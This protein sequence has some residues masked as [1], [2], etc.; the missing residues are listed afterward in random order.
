MDVQAVIV[1]GIG[2]AACQA[3]VDNDY[4]LPPSAYLLLVVGVLR[5]LGRDQADKRKRRYR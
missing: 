4:G 2:V 5:F 3:G 1:P